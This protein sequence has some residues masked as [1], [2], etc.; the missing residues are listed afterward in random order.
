M[1]GSPPSN[2][3]IPPV[4]FKEDVISVITV[5]NVYFPT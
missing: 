5:N 2:D 1:S 3:D 4:P